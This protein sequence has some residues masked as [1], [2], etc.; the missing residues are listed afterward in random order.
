MIFY[1]WTPNWPQWR[2]ITPDEYRLCLAHITRHP[3]ENEGVRTLARR[4]E[5][6]EE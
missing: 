6:S 1:L 3:E 4:L 2:R 5:A